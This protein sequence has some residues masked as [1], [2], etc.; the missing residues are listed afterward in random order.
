ME[1]GYSIWK[2]VACKAC[3]VSLAGVCTVHAL[4]APGEQPQPIQF[5]QSDEHPERQ[6]APRPQQE[7]RVTAPSSSSVMPGVSIAPI[8]SGE[9]T[10]NFSF[11]FVNT[12][13]K[14]TT[15]FG[16]RSDLTSKS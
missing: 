3:A 14:Q 2:N 10:G 9:L 6:P 11:T 4:K 7:N 16:T 1:S 12:E 15:V 8:I 13:G 5:Y